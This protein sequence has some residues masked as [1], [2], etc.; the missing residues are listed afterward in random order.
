MGMCMLEDSRIS[1][2]FFSELFLSSIAIPVSVEIR[3]YLVNKTEKN[4]WLLQQGFVFNFLSRPPKQK[5]ASMVC[6]F[7]RSSDRTSNTAVLSASRI[8]QITPTSR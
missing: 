2:A 6:F 1:I 8:V 4:T 5:I 7:Q 3:R